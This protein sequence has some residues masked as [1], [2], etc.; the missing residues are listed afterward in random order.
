MQCPRKQDLL[1]MLQLQL[2]V[3]SIML[4]LLQCISKK[5][6]QLISPSQN[7]PDCK[8]LCNSV[9]NPNASRQHYAA[10][11]ALYQQ[12]ISKKLLQLSSPSQTIPDCKTSCNY[13]QE[14]RNYTV[15]YSC[16]CSYKYSKCAAA[17]QQSHYA[18]IYVRDNSN[19]DCHR[20]G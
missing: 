5:L 7:I 11:A 9:Q 17:H 10:I 16:S 12:C 13:V 14:N 3:C 4:Q 20:F 6:L 18:L 2:Q 19:E 1:S 15:C 8:I